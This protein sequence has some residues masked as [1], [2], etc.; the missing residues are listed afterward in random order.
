MTDMINGNKNPTTRPFGVGKLDSFKKFSEESWGAVGK[1]L[2]GA[3]LVAVLM[4]FSFY[5]TVT[6]L[7][8][9]VTQESGSSTGMAASSNTG[10]AWYSSGSGFLIVLAATL[11]ILAAGCAAALCF[12]MN[13]DS[14]VIAI[15]AVILLGFMYH[16]AVQSAIDL[17][18]TWFFLWSAVVVVFG[19]ILLFWSYNT[20]NVTLDDTLITRRNVPNDDDNKVALLTN[21]IKEI[22]ERKKVVMGLGI[23][24]IVSGLVLLVSHWEIWN[25]IDKTNTEQQP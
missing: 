14:I 22:G 16:F 5:Y 13:R 15:L 8:K 9:D 23:L 11:F 12:P 20:I 18:G 7:F 19:G 10:N 4:G 21:N 6:P 1:I 24:G 17:Y 25:L 2:I 3:I